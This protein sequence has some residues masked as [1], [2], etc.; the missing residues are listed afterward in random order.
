MKISCLMPTYNRC[1]DYQVL[2]EEALECFLSQTYDDKELI[3]C[4]DTPGQK[5]IFDHPQVKV[6]NLHAR[7]PTLSDKLQWMI[8]N[9]S[10]DVLCRWDDDDISLPHRLEYSIT[11]LGHDLEWRAENYWYCPLEDTKYVEHPGNT[12]TM[13]VW[14]REVLNHFGGSYPEK[15]SGWE[16]QQF[17][18]Q[19]S[20][21][22]INNAGDII[23]I[24]DIFYLYRWGVSDR[25]L[26]S[27][28]AGTKEGLQSHYDKIGERDVHQEEF[29]L[30]PHWEEDYI[31][32]AEKAA[33]EETAVA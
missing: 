12:H 22:G 27:Q 24:E 2:V 16:D 11:K 15:A 1:P 8:D 4:N 17:N 21:A 10:G 20:R 25:H 32:R 29:L 6:L 28:G 7:F 26:S 13:S 18:I 19:L 3:I 30:E 9:S 14:R 31:H 23:P 5:L 33:A